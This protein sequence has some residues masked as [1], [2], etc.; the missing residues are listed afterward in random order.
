M[1]LGIVLGPLMEENLRRAMIISKGD[2]TV[3]YTR[4][5]SLSL[6]VVAITLLIIVSLPSLRKKRDSAFSEEED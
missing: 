5:L 6:L 3:F 4:P 2:W 1:L